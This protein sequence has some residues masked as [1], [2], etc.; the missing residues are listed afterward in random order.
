MK[1]NINEAFKVSRTKDLR[2]NP[3]AFIDPN[4]PE[5]KN[6]FAYKQIFKDAG[7]EWSASPKFRNIFPPHSQGFWFWF[8]GKSEDQWRNAYERRIKPALEKVHSME[9]VSDE[10]SKESLIASLDAI[11]E[12][13]QSAPPTFD[14][15]AILTKEDREK[16]LSKLQDF[17]TVL[18]N[19]DS[20]EEFKATLK[21]IITFRSAQG[22]Q[23]SL[24]NTFLVMVQR[25]DA[26][27]VKSKSNWAKYNR[28]INKGAEPIFLWKPSK[29]G[30]IPFSKEERNNIIIK[31]LNGI[32][33]NSIDELTP[34]ERERLDPKLAGRFNGKDFELYDVY[35]ISDTTLIEGKED[36]IKPSIENDDE[37]KWHTEEKSEEVRPIYG[38]LLDFANRKGLTVKHVGA[39]VLDGARGLSTGGKI[40]ILDNEGNDV[41]LTKTLAHE[42]SHELLHQEYLKEKDVE[43]K[44]FFIGRSEGRGMVEQQAELVAWMVLGAFGFDT[45][46]TS[47]NYVA[48]WGGKPERMVSVFDNVAQTANYLISE[49]MKKKVE[50]KEIEANIPTGKK[51]YTSMDVANILGVGREFENLLQKEKKIKPIK[52]AMIE[53]FF[54]LAENK[55]KLDE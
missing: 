34:Q 52:D 13:I 19:I 50:L 39:E 1:S 18:T 12:K 16:I 11:I 31:F 20:D 28:V 2:G 53:N 14:S 32:G 8:I 22:H 35:D 7:A 48:I 38:A 43:L 17:K 6:T 41:G 47:L 46:T 10:E 3:I 30:I 42:I 37:I 33:K 40:Y 36:L 25:P 49:I 26:T 9:G 21:K 15:D 29:Q 27:M 44:Q 45:K 51:H 5:N 55:N 24:Q 23:F 54:R 4:A